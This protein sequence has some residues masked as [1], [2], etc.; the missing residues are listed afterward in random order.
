MHFAVL[1]NISS[2]LKLLSICFFRQTKSTFLRSLGLKIYRISLTQ[3]YKHT[4]ITGPDFSLSD[5]NNLDCGKVIVWRKRKNCKNTCLKEIIN[6]RCGSCYI[7]GSGSS[8][9]D[10]DFSALKNKTLFGV[11]GAI[12]DCLIKWVGKRLRTLK[13]RV[14]GIVYNI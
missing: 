2:I 4:A 9:S 11:N 3:K 14:S 13:S 6:S 1:Y 5:D 8:V 10:V 12:K 7:V